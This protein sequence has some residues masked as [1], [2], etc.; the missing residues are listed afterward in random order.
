MQV[1]E[2]FA[3]GWRWGVP[4]AHERCEE[5]HDRLIEE[6]LGLG[7]VLPYVEDAEDA[8]LLVEAGAVADESVGN[9][10]RRFHVLAYGVVVRGASI[11]AADR[12]LLNECNGYVDVLLGR[13]A[14]SYAT[15]GSRREL[16]PM[17]PCQVVLLSPWGKGGMRVTAPLPRPDSV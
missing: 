6:P 13:L 12:E 7:L 9:T 17:Q 10:N 8:C 3:S 16:V 4:G 5:R 1:V 15:G 14:G 2:P 11:V